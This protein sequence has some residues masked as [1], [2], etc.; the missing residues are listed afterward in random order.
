MKL[1]I[2]S[3]MAKTPGSC[4]E[5]PLGFG[6]WCAYTP[7]E[8]DENCPHEGRP[9]WCP[10]HTVRET[11]LSEITKQLLDVISLSRKNGL[12]CVHIGDELTEKLLAAIIN[13][14]RSARNRVIPLDELKAIG[15][16]YGEDHGLPMP[17]WLEERHPGR[18]SD[19]LSFGQPWYDVDICKQEED[20]IDDMRMEWLGSDLDG[21]YDC[22]GYGVSWRCWEKKPT[23]EEREETGWM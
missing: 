6:G 1:L 5:C 4:H 13:P 23:K 12:E 17:V 22:A 10:M 14:E 9:W 18:G 8:I 7:A 20:N 16:L 19:G 3:N 11:N 2:D 21:V 15:E